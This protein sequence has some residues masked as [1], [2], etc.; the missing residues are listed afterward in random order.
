MNNHEVKIKKPFIELK[1]ITKHFGG[2]YALREISLDIYKGEILALVGDNG[3]GKSTLIKILSGAY[4]ADNGEIFI[5]EAK[6]SIE[7]PRDAKQYN[8]ETIYQNL[9][10]MDNL[11]IPSNIFIGRELFKSRILKFLKIVDYKK[12]TGETESVLGKLNVKI[13]NLHEKVFNLSGGQ[14]QAVAISRTIYFNAQ[15]IIMDEPTAALGVEE[16][17]KVYDLVLELKKRGVAVIIISHNINE[18]FDVADKIAVLKNGLLVGVKE[19][20]N[21]TIN[22]ILK[23]IIVGDSELRR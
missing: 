15:V 17:R 21:T 11:D 10:L 4:T 20:K 22:E 14:R 8:I 9:A 2:I 5:D 7:S 18:I 6:V 23:M 1:S 12:M 16:T 19:K 13:K 3:A